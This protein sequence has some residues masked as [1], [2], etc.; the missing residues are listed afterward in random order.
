[1][2]INYEE[3][4]RLIEKKSVKI[5]GFFSVLSGTLLILMLITC[6]IW[7]FY[8]D[9]RK[10][11]GPSMQPTLNNYANSYSQY[12]IVIV[13]K[14][15]NFSRQDIVTIDFSNYTKDELII[16]RVIAL[17][18]DQVKIEWNPTSQKSDVLIKK[19]GEKEFKLLVEDYI[20]KDQGDCAK[21]FKDGVETGYGS[22]DSTTYKWHGYSKNDDGSITILDGYFFAL[23]DNREP[24]T[25]SSELGPFESKRVNGIVE[26]IEKNGTFVHKF[27][28]KLCNLK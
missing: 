6:M 8:H 16:K 19:K 15:Q 4:S 13:N 12:D 11:S 3:K 18:G 22:H 24:S 2:R 14:S 17:A 28:Q 23:G 7:C 25:D 5:A 21:T 26:T 20:K 1:M 27:I 9:V 10:I